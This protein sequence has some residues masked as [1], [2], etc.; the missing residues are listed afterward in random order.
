[1]SVKKNRITITLSKTKGQYGYDSWT[2]L[3]QT[4][5]SAALDKDP[6]AGLMDMMKQSESRDGQP[7]DCGRERRPSDAALSR[8]D[9]TRSSPCACRSD[10]LPTL[11]QALH[12]AHAVNFGRHPRPRSGHVR[13]PLWMG[14]FGRS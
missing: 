4:R 6:G 1:M 7:R 13:G 10:F 11:W 14:S 8:P 12:E 3:K 2:D 5:Q 9:T